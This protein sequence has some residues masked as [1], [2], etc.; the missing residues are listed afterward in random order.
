MRDG[1]KLSIKLHV[2]KIYSHKRICT[3]EDLSDLNCSRFVVKQTLL[4]NSLMSGPVTLLCSE[5]C[6]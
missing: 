5:N 2:Y 3:H 6:I 1:L 4:F